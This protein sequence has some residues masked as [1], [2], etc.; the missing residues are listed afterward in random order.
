MTNVIFTE[1]DLCVWKVALTGIIL[2]WSRLDRAKWRV[3][4][5]VH[6]REGNPAPVSGAGAPNGQSHWLGSPQPDPSP[7]HC[8]PWYYHIFLFNNCGRKHERVHIYLPHR[9]FFFFFFLTVVVSIKWRN[10]WAKIELGLKQ[11][12]KSKSHY[13]WRKSVGD[14]C[15]LSSVSAN[16]QNQMGGPGTNAQTQAHPCFK[17]DL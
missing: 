7:T 5:Q 15:D 13:T 2:K 3:M 12:W 6:Y 11:I 1:D 8:L 10:C 9:P 14:F 16:W 17:W 4:Q